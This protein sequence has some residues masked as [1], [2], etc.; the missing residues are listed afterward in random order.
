MIN[1]EYEITNMIMLI[2]D[3]RS[4]LKKKDLDI[5]IILSWLFN[6]CFSQINTNLKVKENY[7]FL[8]NLVCKYLLDKFLMILRQT[9]QAPVEN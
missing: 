6:N 5:T 7:I 2:K 8:I 1:L 4:K 9:S 3:L